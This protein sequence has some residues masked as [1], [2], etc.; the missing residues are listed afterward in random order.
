MKYIDSENKEQSPIILH[1]AILGS[2]ER[3][4][5]ILL[6]SFGKDFP[7]FLK[8]AFIGIEDKRFYFHSGIDFL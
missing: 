7:E 6:E 5:G 4:I 8:T 1:H 2:L 3:M